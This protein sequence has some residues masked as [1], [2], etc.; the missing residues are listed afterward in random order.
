MVD[1]SAP[2]M[3]GMLTKN[4]DALLQV[5]LYFIIL[6]TMNCV[7]F[8]L[9]TSCNVNSTSCASSDLCNV[10]MFDHKSYNISSI[11]VVLG[12]TKIQTEDHELQRGV[13]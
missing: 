5:S 10:K 12:C 3:Q 13:N 4:G 8:L 1:E 2:D 6:A 11:L 7:F 9:H